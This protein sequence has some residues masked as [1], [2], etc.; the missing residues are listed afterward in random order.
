[1]DQAQLDNP[2]WHSLNGAHAGLAQGR[3][4]VRWYPPSFTPFIAVASVDTA[5]DRAAV[6]R[7]CDTAGACF[8][9]VLPRALPEGWRFHSRSAVHQMLYAPAQPP[10]VDESRCSVLGIGQRPEMLALARLAFPDFFRERTAEL[11]TYLGIFQDGRLAAMAGERMALDGLREISGVC[12]HPDHTGR[13][14]ARLLTHA[15]LHRHRKQGLNTFLHVSEGNVAARGLY[16]AMGF[17][18]R[19]TLEMG[20]VE[21]IA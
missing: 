10:A 4:G 5:L 18:V 20:R 17:A 7:D 13:G 16:Q 14:H 1:M 3:G 2:I 21:R 9:G 8:L 11:G 12:T 6:A 19:T 15:L